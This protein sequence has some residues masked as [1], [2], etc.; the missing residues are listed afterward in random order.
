MREQ[1]RQ[2]QHSHRNDNSPEVTILRTF[3]GEDMSNQARIVCTSEFNPWT[4]ERCNT[5]LV[6][7]GGGRLRRA[8]RERGGRRSKGRFR[9]KREHHHKQ[10]ISGG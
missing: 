7:G 2:A 3:V 1:H 8:L 9:C 10:Q 6:R 5:A 4:A